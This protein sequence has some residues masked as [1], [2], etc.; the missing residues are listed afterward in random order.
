MQT[1]PANW[2]TYYANPLHTTEYKVTISEKDGSNPATYGMESIKSASIESALLAADMWIGNVVAK[3]LSMS[4]LAS[5]EVS[6]MAKIVMQCRL[7]LN[8]NYTDYVPVG[9]FWVD[10]RDRGSLWRNFVCYDDMLMLDQ[11]FID[12]ELESGEWPLTMTEAVAE[13]CSRVG[14]TLDTGTTIL[15]GTDYVVPYTNDLTMREVLGYI[16]ICHGGNW[17]ITA[18][19][20]LQIVILASPG[21]VKQAF[22]QSVKKFYRNRRNAY[23]IPCHAL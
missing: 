2:D 22:G 20:K 9:T 1:A 21:T 3:K 18:Q 8:G 10:E 16:G 5:V 19:R 6:R 7:E 4:V 13:I 15:T 14:L 12:A 17:T 11:P 23:N